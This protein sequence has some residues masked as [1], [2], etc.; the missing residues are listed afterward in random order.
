[1]FLIYWKSLSR[2]SFYWLKLTLAKWKT[3]NIHISGCH[4]FNPR[5]FYLC[6][7]V[8]SVQ[9]NKQIVFVLPSLAN[10]VL[11]IIFKKLFFS[12][13]AFFAKQI[14]IEKS[15]I[16]YWHIASLSTPQL[17]EN[18]R[19]FGKPRTASVW[20]DASWRPEK[21]SGIHCLRNSG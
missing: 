15:I 2:D 11:L 14:L 16:F 21:Q 7:I 9:K 12:F 20:M 4:I 8:V 13:L 18:V 5:S 6:Q 19:L 17:I 1:M 10:L 3:R